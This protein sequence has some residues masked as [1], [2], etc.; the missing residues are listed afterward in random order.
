MGRKWLNEW[1]SPLRGGLMPL[2][3]REWELHSPVQEL[4]TCGRT[5]LPPVLS[6]QSTRNAVASSPEAGRKQWNDDLPPPLLR[7]VQ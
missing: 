5:L 1:L 4:Y 6:R 3:A 7:F 2:G